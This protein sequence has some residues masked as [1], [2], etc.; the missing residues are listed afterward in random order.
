MRDAITLPVTPK[1]QAIAGQQ[2]YFDA[3]AN[4]TG[5]TIL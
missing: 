3:K 2:D 4:I 1:N 5:K